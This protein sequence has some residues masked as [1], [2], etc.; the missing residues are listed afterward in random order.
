MSVAFDTLKAANR[1]SAAGFPQDQAESLAAIFSEG[2]TENL[3]T[4]DDLELV[5]KDIKTLDAKIDTSIAA[6]DSKIDTSIAALDAKIDTSIAALDSKID[7]SIAAVQKDIKSLDTKIDTSTAAL[8]TKIDTSIA[9]LSRDLT[10]KL[11]YIVVGGITALKVI[12]N[13][14][15]N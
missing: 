11:S 9:K 2:I 6:L 15:L 10:I 3:A 14:I 5:R 8:D 7:T 4:K 13:Y 12:E 1:L